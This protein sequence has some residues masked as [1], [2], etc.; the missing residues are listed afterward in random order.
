MDF[1]TRHLIAETIGELPNLTPN[2]MGAK[3]ARIGE[4]LK[5]SGFSWAALSQALEANMDPRTHDAEFFD[6]VR[7]EN[8]VCDMLDALE[9]VR[10]VLPDWQKKF[11]RDMILRLWK[12]RDGFWLTAKQEALLISIWRSTLA[13]HGEVRKRKLQDDLQEADALLSDDVRD[14]AAFLRREPPPEP[15]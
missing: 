1:Q 4:M 9:P 7:A 5:K 14:A 15:A 10:K 12:D 2:Q 3:M 8:M 6:K 11:L 13:I